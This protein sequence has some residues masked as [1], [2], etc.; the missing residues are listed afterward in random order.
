[1]NK[2]TERDHRYREQ[3]DVAKGEEVGEMG[4]K[5]KKEGEG[6]YTCND[7]TQI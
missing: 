3:F 4:I 5:L 6:K 7:E 2:K 1:M